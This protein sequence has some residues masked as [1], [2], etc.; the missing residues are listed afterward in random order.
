MTENSESGSWFYSPPVGPSLS[1]ATLDDV[2]H[3][4]HQDDEYWSTEAPAT[5]DDYCRENWAKL[6]Y[7][8]IDH[9]AIINAEVYYIENSLFTIGV[10]SPK[11][12]QFPP[13]LNE[14][15]RQEL[16]F[17]WLFAYPFQGENWSDNLCVSRQGNRFCYPKAIC[18]NRE[19]LATI[20]G[21]L[22]ETLTLSNKFNWITELD[23][24]RRYQRWFYTPGD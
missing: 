20:I 7:S 24:A 9:K 17:E 18:V 3:S 11:F 22:Y 14:E 13:E 4:L 19:L 10:R 12:T 1:A 15:E 21:E 6:I 23:F 5:A 2:L 16:P 8:D